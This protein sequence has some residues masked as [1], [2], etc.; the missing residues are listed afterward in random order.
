MTCVITVTITIIIIN[1]T[2]V[3]NI[4]STS[5]IIITIIT[6]IIILLIVLLYLKKYDTQHIAT[7]EYVFVMLQLATLIM[8]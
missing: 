5:I 1:H 2:I 8:I 3:I 7:L 6:L 4:I